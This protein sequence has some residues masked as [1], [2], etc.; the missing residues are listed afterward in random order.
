M[1]GRL[2]N[3][4]AGRV[5][6]TRIMTKQQ[7][8]MSQQASAISKTYIHSYQQEA[9]YSTFQSLLVVHVHFFN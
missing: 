5:M 2:S 8:T 3:Y 9:M 1:K 7:A 4:S 6:I